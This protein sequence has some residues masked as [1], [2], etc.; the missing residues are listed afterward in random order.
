MICSLFPNR[1]VE[2]LIAL[3]RYSLIYWLDNNGLH[4]YIDNFWKNWNKFFR[5]YIPSSSESWNLKQFFYFCFQDS[6]KK[7]PAK[8]KDPSESDPDVIELDDEDEEI[9]DVEDAEEVKLI[10]CRVEVTT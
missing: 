7:S 5:V 3:I 4:Y 10:F 6:A 9:D 1:T 8:K 2:S